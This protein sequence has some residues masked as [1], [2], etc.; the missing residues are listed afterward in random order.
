MSVFGT[1]DDLMRDLDE[2]EMIFRLGKD[3]PKSA[4][5]RHM[6]E[7]NAEYQAAIDGCGGDEEAE[8]DVDDPFDG[9]EPF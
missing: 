1:P 8:A 6:D 9:C 5:L 2:L 4:V 3:A 7:A